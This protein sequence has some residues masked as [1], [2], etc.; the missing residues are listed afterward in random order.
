ME[1]REFW[2]WLG[3]GAVALGGIGL[4]VIGLMADAQPEAYWTTIAVTVALILSGVLV[5]YLLKQH[6]FFGPRAGRGLRAVWEGPLPPDHTGMP[7]WYV[8][9]QVT[10]PMWVLRVVGDSPIYSASGLFPDPNQQ[11]KVGP[12]G[13]P[14]PNVRL[15]LFPV[16]GGVEPGHHVIVNVRSTEPLR[17][18]RVIP[19]PLPLALEKALVAGNRRLKP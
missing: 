11:V 10:E 16:A 13:S 2:G 14:R 8:L 12:L 6:L 4:G 7:G 18:V 15:L 9:L 17:V 5:L 3:G 19:Q 1:R